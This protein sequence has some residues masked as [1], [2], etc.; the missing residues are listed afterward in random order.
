MLTFSMPTPVVAASEMA[1]FCR[2]T[3]ATA[4]RPS[5]R[6]SPRPAFMELPAR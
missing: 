1:T 4:P 6:L 2:P 5:S 3:L